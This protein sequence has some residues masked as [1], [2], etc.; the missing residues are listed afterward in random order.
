LIELRQAI[1]VGHISE[2]LLDLKWQIFWRSI[3][4]PNIDVSL[5]KKVGYL[6]SHIATTYYQDSLDA[7]RHWPSVGVVKGLLPILVHFI[8]LSVLVQDCILVK[9]V[10]EVLFLG[11][12]VVEKAICW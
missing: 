10:F 5:G 2:K 1:E 8:L 6:R 3:E 9:T 11:N 12:D 4:G 7:F